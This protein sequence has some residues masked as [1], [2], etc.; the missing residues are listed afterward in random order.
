EF[1]ARLLSQP[2]PANHIPPQDRAGSS[3]LHAMSRR[4]GVECLDPLEEFLNLSLGY[5]G[6]NIPS[7]QAFINWQAEEDTT[8]KR[9]MESAGGHVRIMTVHG[10]KGLQ[11]PIVFLPDTAHTGQ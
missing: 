2:C 1:F 6:D 4:L 9:E 11:A 8:I 10:S 5:E 3:G 7:L